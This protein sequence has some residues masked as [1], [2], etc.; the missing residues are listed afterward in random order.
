MMK[1]H[2]CEKVGD[3]EQEKMEN[4]EKKQTSFILKEK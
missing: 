4:T 2:I 3:N 1:T